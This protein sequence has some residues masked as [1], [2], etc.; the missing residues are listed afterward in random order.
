MPSPPIQITKEFSQFIKGDKLPLSTPALIQCSPVETIVKSMTTN[1]LWAYNNLN[2]NEQFMPV[3]TLKLALT[4]LINEI[5]ILAGQISEEDEAGNVHIAVNNTGVVWTEAHVEATLD[6][7]IPHRFARYPE[8]SATELLHSVD[9]SALNSL[10]LTSPLSYGLNQPMLSLQLTRFHC[11]SLVIALSSQHVLFDGSS[12]GQLIAAWAEITTKGY[13]ANKIAWEDRSFLDFSEENKAEI[14]P[15]QFINY[16][17]QEL[18]QDERNGAQQPP[19]A[20]QQKRGFRSE[21]QRNFEEPV[22]AKLLHF[23]AEEVAS[24]KAEAS[25]ELGE[26]Q[27]ISSFDALYAHM[28]ISLHHCQ[29]DEAHSMH[30]A[31]ELNYN[32][33]LP[34]NGRRLLGFNDSHNFFGSL[35]FFLRASVPSSLFSRQHLSLLAQLIHCI[36]NTQSALSLGRFCDFLRPK[37]GQKYSEISQIG[38]VLGR[39]YY[40]TAWNKAKLYGNSDFGWG[41]A[42]Y[43]GPTKYLLRKMMI[44]MDSAVENEEN[45]ANQGGVDVLLGLEERKWTKLAQILR[46]SA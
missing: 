26:E 41:K 10:S 29:A 40:C 34:Y 18:Q 3:D 36:H 42:D 21:I 8:L 35:A 5:P 33:T 31:Q 23:T 39:D 22:V 32:I 14:P 9:Y 44:F 1:I 13:L 30:G 37:K 19:R 25:R 12:A 2:L 17:K 16:S 28:I 7:I 11:D 45:W 43:C 6:S 24:I 20:Q 46:K 4:K 38:D 27:W 15:P